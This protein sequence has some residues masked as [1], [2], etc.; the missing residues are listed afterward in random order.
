MAKY[1]DKG[2]EVTEVQ[3]L[4]SMLGYDLIIDGSFGDKTVRSLQAFQKKMGLVVDGLAGPKT[5][6]ALKA[7]QK[8]TA[9]EEK[10]QPAPKNYGSISVETKYQ[11]DP[12]QYLKQSTPK[13]KIFIHFTAGGP[14]AGN[15]IKYWD[16]DEPRV[17]TA[18]VIGGE[19]GQIYECFSPDFWSFHLGIKGTNGALDKSSI[20][21]E[22]CAWGPLTKKGDEFYTYVNTKVPADQVYELDVPFRGFKYFHKVSDEQFKQLELLVDFLINKYDVPVQKS[23]DTSWFE[24]NQ[25]LINKKTPG[26]W[27]HTNVRKDKSDMYPDQRL[28]DM[29]NR[30]AKK[31]NP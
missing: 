13:D 11:L 30:F 2:A 16:S 10:G 29:L 24:F 15:V 8:R 21:I 20:G 23:F 6:E 7:A 18:F 19:T 28:I 17:A 12:T 25:E 22:I 27:T 31:Y 14:N 3:K 1:G 5:I 26:I 9:K 4:L